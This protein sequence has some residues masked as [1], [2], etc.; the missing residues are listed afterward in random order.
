M[1]EYEKIF[2]DDLSF[3]ALSIYRYLRYRQGKNESCYQSHKTIARDNSCSV[4]T[5][6]RAI[7]ELVK[8]GYIEKINR[9]R[10]NG[11]KTSNMY[12]CK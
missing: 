4:S 8:K 11:S 5:V 9:R 10:Q 12:I 2:H 7:D 1:R 6:R 3:R